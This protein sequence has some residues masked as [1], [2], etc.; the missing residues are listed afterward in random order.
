M[1]LFTHLS[2]DR[3]IYVCL[4]LVLKADFLERNPISC[5]ELHSKRKVIMKITTYALSSRCITLNLL[6]NSMFALMLLFSVK[7]WADGISLNDA[8]QVAIQSDPAQ[9]IYQAQQAS[10]IA[11]GIAGSTLDDPMIKLGVANLPTDSFQLNQEAMT[12]VAVGLSQQ[13]NRGSTLELTQKN[14]NQRSDIAEYQGLDRQLMVKKTVRELWF[15]ILFMD[16]SLQIIKE[17]K[18][19]F[20]GFYQ[21]LKTSYSLGLAENED[22]IAAEI[23]IN[24]FDEKTAAL[25]QQSLNYRSLL[26]E[27]IGQYAYQ[28]LPTDMPKWPETLSYINSVKVKNNQHYDL[29]SQHPKVKMFVMNIEVADNGIALAEQDYKPSYKVE[30]GY[31]LRLSETDMGQPRPDLL[32]AFVSMDIPLFTDKRQDQKLIS[33]Q[34][35]KGQKQAEHRLILRQL[36]ALLTAEISNYQ[37]LKARQTRYQETLLVQAKQHSKLLEQSYQSNTRPFKE[38]IEAYIHEQN[39]ALEYQQ[40][41]FDSLKSLAEIRY[42]QAL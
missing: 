17:N 10:L 21:D 2:K 4:T 6:L 3:L 1:F 19:L 30:V 27:Y 35:N 32:S 15:N 33:A 37:Q 18:K 26:H 14:F 41:Y 12:Q 24:K 25:T 16:K 40:L 13:F 7:L 22:L 38:V 20:L 29:L 39:L 5:K 42:F 34:Y 23:E 8:E 36:N 28:A 31:G 9:T 11:Q